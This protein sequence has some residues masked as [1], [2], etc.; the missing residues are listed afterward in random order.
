MIGQNEEYSY[1]R[2]VIYN[3]Y[4]KVNKKVIS[5]MNDLMNYY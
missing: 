4:Q 3:I 2:L 5:I 1:Y